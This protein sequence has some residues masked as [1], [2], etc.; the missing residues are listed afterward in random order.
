MAEP[1]PQK[2]DTPTPTAAPMTDQAGADRPSSLMRD[3]RT[4]RTLDP[5]R[6]NLPMPRNADQGDRIDLPGG[7]GVPEHKQ[8]IDALHVAADAIHG[9]D[10]GKKFPMN[11]PWA[12]HSQDEYARLKEYAAEHLKDQGLEHVAVPEDPRVVKPFSAILVSPDVKQ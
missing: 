8:A 4:G 7:H 6:P 1:K 11:A 5:R 2:T 10:H 12:G 3:P 9:E